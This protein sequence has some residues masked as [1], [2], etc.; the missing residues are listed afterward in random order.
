M[1]SILLSVLFLVL[2]ASASSASSED[3]NW[4]REC[5]D[6][7]I[8]RFAHRLDAKLGSAV[9]SYNVP[10]WAREF[11]DRSEEAYRVRYSNLTRESAIRII[12]MLES[13]I[14]TASSQGLRCPHPRESPVLLDGRIV[15]VCAPR[16]DCSTSTAGVSTLGSGAFASEKEISIR[17]TNT[18]LSIVFFVLGAL[19]LL[20]IFVQLIVTAWNSIP[21]PTL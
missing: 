15:C 21:L 6:S 4:I 14:F 3:I 9:T 13:R 10:E 1:P 18:T 20:A 5:A 7:P 19:V 8:C 16:H 12:A 11:V 17:D 2:T